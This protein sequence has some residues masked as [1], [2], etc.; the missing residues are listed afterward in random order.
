MPEDPYNDAYADENYTNITPVIKAITID[1][2][3]DEYTPTPDDE[4][5]TSYAT[6]ASKTPT[7]PNSP[8]EEYL[9]TSQIQS[10]R[11][12]DPTKVKKL[13]IL[14]LNGTLAF[15]NPHNPRKDHPNDDK[16]SVPQKEPSSDDVYAQFPPGQH[17]L[18]VVNPRPYMPSFREYVFHPKTRKWLDTM[19]WSSAQ[20]H[21]VRDMVEKC[22]G[23]DAVE[24]EEHSHNRRGR[25]GRHNRS[26]GVEVDEFGREKR[27]KLVA[28]WA[29][30]TLGLDSNAYHRKT[31]T[32]KDLNKPW[33]WSRIHSAET[34]VLLDDSP[35]K[36]KL[37]PH[38]HLCVPEYSRGIREWDVG[39]LERARLAKGARENPAADPH[40]S[41]SVTS[42]TQPAVAE[43]DKKD[44]SRPNSSLKRKRTP[45]SSSYDHIL[46]AVIGVLDAIKYQSNVSSWIREQGI[47]VDDLQEEEE[48]EEEE[49]EDDLH[50]LYLASSPDLGAASESIVDP[51]MRK[52]AGP[53]AR[54][55]TNKN[56]KRK[57]RKVD[58]E[59]DVVLRDQLAEAECSGGGGEEPVNETEAGKGDADGDVS[60]ASD[61]TSHHDEPTQDN[62]TSSS[63]ATLT[64]AGPDGS[65]S[66]STFKPSPLTYTESIGTFEPIAFLDSS[67]PSSS[68]TNNPPSADDSITIPGLDLPFGS[69]PAGAIAIDNTLLS[70]VP[71]PP[72]IMWFQDRRTRLYWV[73]R[74]RK[75][76]EELGIE[77]IPGV[78]PPK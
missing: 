53:K 41:S 6:P 51:N 39:V 50:S 18:R 22:F 62:S 27:G 14:D 56:I 25:K 12:E 40:E 20:P 23:E 35:L 47:W 15:R 31:Q 42:P 37:Q 13:L 43:E 21:S 1:P 64:D 71:T 66:T 16:G 19:V 67:K 69:A 46:L 28:A 5:V 4:D 8:S 33:K 10:T 61:S 58:G 78:I 45:S 65:T 26:H 36:A 63:A 29:R 17:P 38:N 48:E 3:S 11:L 70:P 49:T 73:E 9:N 34:T 44:H 32:T 59:G 57:R 75:A 74:G 76:L 77:C 54:W 72:P 52:R 68:S 24:E 7:T 55:R 60:D 2:Y 30:D